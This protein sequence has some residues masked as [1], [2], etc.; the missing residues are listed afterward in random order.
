MSPGLFLAVALLAAPEPECGEA[1]LP[2]IDRA[3]YA[4]VNAM[5][6]SAGATGE[7]APVYFAEPLASALQADDAR[8]ARGETPRLAP[9]WLSGGGRMDAVTDVR[10]YSLNRSGT[11]D[12]VMGLGFTNAEGEAVYRRL[13][14]GC[15]G[16]R[17]RIRAVFLHPEGV[18]VSE[19]LDAA[20]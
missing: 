5:T 4:T 18:F 17:W 8:R 9:D 1:G 19:L 3:A 12:I 11:D 13:H 15:Y 10:L 20:P 2:D 16:G 14:L 7:P 6:A